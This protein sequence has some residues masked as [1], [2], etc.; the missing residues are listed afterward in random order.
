MNV[1]LTEKLDSFVAEQVQQGRYRSAS[2]VVREGL[3]LLEVREAKLENLRAHLDAGRASG[4]RDGEVAMD[5]IRQNLKT[6]R[7][8]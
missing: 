2:E 8:A 3:R 4:Y 1:S 5:R 6:K 7:G